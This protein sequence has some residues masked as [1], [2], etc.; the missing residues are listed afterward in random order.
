[1]LDLI[2]TLPP[3]KVDFTIQDFQGKTALMLVIERGESD[4]AQA[5]IKALVTTNADL[6]IEDNQ[7]NTALMMAFNNRSLMYDLILSGA[8][9]PN[10]SS[11]MMTI[12]SQTRNACV[13]QLCDAEMLP[14]S[15]SLKSLVKE[16]IGE[17]Y[18]SLPFSSKSILE[19][20]MSRL[21]SLQAMH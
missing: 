11:T 6:D 19:M 20:A 10:N 2:K 12:F 21:F 8:P 18:E 14:I 13:H 9:I 1:M 17:G 4:I 3:K 16:Y 15:T 5:L 7:G